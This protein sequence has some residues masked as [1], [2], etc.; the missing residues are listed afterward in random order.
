MGSD[1]IKDIL[2]DIRDK[3]GDSSMFLYGDANIKPVESISTGSLSIDAATGI[4]GV[5]KGRITE[6]Y[7]AESS[8]KT[9]L[10]L[11]L[12][13]EAQIAGGRCAFIDVEHALDIKYAKSLGVDVNSLLISQPNYGEEALS[14]VEMLVKTNEIDLIIVDSVAALT[15]KAEIDGEMTDQQMGLQARMLSKGLR[16]IN[17]F[18]TTAKTALVFINQMRSNIGVMFGNP[19]VTTGGKALK[20]YTSM[21]IELSKQSLIKKADNVIGQNVVA[22][23]VKNKTASPFQNAEF[24]IIYG[25]GINKLDEVLNLSV[26]FGIIQKNGSWYS[27]NGEKLS[28]G[29]DL[30]I[31]KLEENKIF[32]EDIFSKVMNHMKN[33]TNSNIN[34]NEDSKINEE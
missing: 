19:N 9:T 11:S 23:I 26:Q 13:R 14:I 25:K 17:S 2:R 5:P 21:R 27:Y 8:G 29:K 3:F 15:P 1:T 18:L 24:Q 28:Q 7:G 30:V 20:Y 12:I 4:N 31:K 22:K 16:K 10:C 32:F 34:I 6:I 33:S